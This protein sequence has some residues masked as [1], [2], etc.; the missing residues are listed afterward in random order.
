MANHKSLDSVLCIYFIHSLIALNSCGVVQSDRAS[1]VTEKTDQSGRPVKGTIH[2]KM[3]ICRKTSYPQA[4]QDVDEFVSSWRNVALHHLL[5]NGSSIVNGCRQN[6]S[7]NITIVHTTPVH[8]LTSCEVK[9]WSILKIFY[10]SYKH[11]A[12]G[13]L[14]CF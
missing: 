12:C 2:P 3:K 8:Q 6:E 10:T 1:S 4:V 5:S 14:W 13:I 7:Q 11:V 9:C